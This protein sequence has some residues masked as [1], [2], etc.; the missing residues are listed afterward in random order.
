MQHSWSIVIAL[1]AVL[2]QQP[3]QIPGVKIDV[4]S[5]TPLPGVDLPREQVAAPIQAVTSKDIERAGA[6]DLSSF[7][8]ERLANVHINEIQGNPFQADVNYRGYTASPLLGTPQGISVYMDGVRLNQP[9]GDVVSWDLIPR[10]AIASTTLM[11]GSNPIFGLNTLGG[12]L[13]I[14]TKDGRNFKGGSAQAT[15]GSHVRRALEFEYGG[16][17]TRGWHWY[18]TGNRFGE[19]GWRDTSHSD[20]RQLFGKLGHQD[21][22]NDI[23]FT[24][25]LA[26]NSLNG[27]ALQEQG[28]LGRNYSSIYT[29][30]DNTHNRSG[31][32]NLAAKRTVSSN[33]LLSGNIYYRDIRT[34]TLNADIN[35][36]SLDQSVYQ[37]GAAERMALTNA[38]Y[39]GF[40]TSGATAANT[41]FP[42]WRCIGN[43][44]IQ[45]EPGEKCTGLINR[46]N[47]G[48][49]NFGLSGQFMLFG[50]HGANKNQL[51]AGGA[52]DRSRVAFVQSTELGY[53]N[54]DRSVTG[55]NAFAD[56]VTGGDVD[57]APFD[58]RSNL[59]GLVQTWSAYA[60]DTYSLGNS[61]S[62][63]F[64]A[65]YNR[66]TVHN[67]DGIQPGGGPGSLDGDHVFDRLNPAVGVTYSPTETVNLYASYSEASRAA[68]S[69][70][71]GCADPV[72]PCKLP[73]ALAGDPALKQ[74]IAR[75]VET[76]ARSKSGALLNWNVSYFHADNSNDILFVTSAQSGFGY[77]K[78]FGKTRR[79]GLEVE[80]NKTFLEKVTLGGGY[81]LLDATY[82]S[83][84]TVNGTGNSSNDAG[85]GLEGTIDIKP[86]NRIPLTPRHMLKTYIDY[87]ALKSLSFD[88]S[89]VAVSSS[90]ARVNENSLHQPDGVY[91]L[92][93]GKS[94]GYG[95]VDA[96]ARYQIHPKLELIAQLNNVFNKRY[97]TAAQIGPFGFTDSE[98]FIARPFPAING[99]FPVRQS[100]FFAPGAPRQFSVGTRVRF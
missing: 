33:L 66:T 91:Y 7:L 8:N 22:R 13:S 72:S 68:T 79:Q 69:I 35:E 76:G 4:I 59:R 87:Q 100:T 61:W 82:Q 98:N 38:G 89:L 45:D 83:A 50:A 94:A 42:F 1:F 32:F 28:M 67:K 65:R 48:Q 14:Q 3:T 26:N 30:P 24:V 73:N 49:H 88:V 41:P 60:T 62:F 95:V 46:S 64:S 47:S 11:P 78:N 57:G 12:S 84:E 97:A 74:V 27:S 85:P 15:Y 40:P 5:T 29:K 9:F 70:E 52:Y 39:S 20:I 43:V 18:V 34:S 96:G 37:P 99:E 58:L 75:T 81:T 17:N 51:T 86:G 6:L 44:L 2:Q 71:L 92:G 25:S 56:G 53:V 31:F 77:F 21:A 93:P 54:P 36:G 16:A 10:N 80:A 23:S 55:V 63:T 90:I 19:N